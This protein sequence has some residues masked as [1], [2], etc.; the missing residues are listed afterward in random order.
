MENI[1]YEFNKI[2]SAT[3]FCKL[4]IT[5]GRRLSDTYHSHDF[6]EIILVIQ[7]SFRHII[8]GREYTHNE[9]DLVILRPGDSHGIKSQSK[10]TNVVCLSVKRTEFEKI[11][12]A[13]GT[14][15]LCDFSPDK[16]PL[17]RSIG[18]DF[19]LCRAC[20]LSATDSGADKCGRQLLG[21]VFPLCTEQDDGVSKPFSHLRSASEKMKSEENLR[22][23]LTAFLRISGYSHTH[24]ARLVKK[25]FGCT[26]HDYI[27]TLRL[28]EAYRRV[29]FTSESF[30]SISACV[31]Y[32]SFSH[33]CRIFKKHYGITPSALRKKHGFATV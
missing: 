11:A 32:E 8:N 18:K 23:G 17:C 19:G 6:Y 16:E 26:L 10:D 14:E 2:A 13:F 25:E 3:D 20:A 9:G 4:Q 30:E 12:S 29:V 22:E 21:I 1:I 27:F 33:F 5:A 31:G 28:E 15:F 24:L 7:G